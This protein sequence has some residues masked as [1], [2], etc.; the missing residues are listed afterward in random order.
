M[1]NSAKYG[2]QHRQAKNV[3]NNKNYWMKQ[4]CRTGSDLEVNWKVPRLFFAEDIGDIKRLQGG[5]AS[6]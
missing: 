1:N 3:E 5:Y 6:E 2:Q 4:P